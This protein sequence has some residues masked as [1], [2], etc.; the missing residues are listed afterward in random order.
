MTTEVRL[1]EGVYKERCS[2]SSSVNGYYTLA[3]TI[4]TELKDILKGRE[5]G[6]YSEVR[7]RVLQRLR[8]LGLT[9][10]VYDEILRVLEYQGVVFVSLRPKT[11]Y[12]VP[13]TYHDRETTITVRYPHIVLEFKDPDGSQIAQVIISDPKRMPLYLGIAWKVLLDGREYANYGDYAIGHI[14]NESMETLQI[15][16][17]IPGGKMIPVFTMITKAGKKEEAIARVMWLYKSGM[18][19]D[20]LRGITDLHRG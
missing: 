13:D 6:D 12:L 7:K 1:N 16:W 20:F 9:P 5:Y 11:I 18:V 17:R 4:L 14:S 8:S 3:G 2:G 15:A 19:K 10:D